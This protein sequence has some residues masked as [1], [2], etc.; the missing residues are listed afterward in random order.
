MLLS[1]MVASFPL[2]RVTGAKKK[3][4]LK[5]LSNLPLPPLQDNSIFLHQG[6]GGWF[7]PPGTLPEE[8]SEDLE[9]LAL[10][11]SA[12][13]LP[14]MATKLDTIIEAIADLRLSLEKKIDKIRAQPSQP[15]QAC[16]H[17]QNAAPEKAS[18]K[19]GKD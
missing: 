9:D 5:D 14:P 19:A 6:P 18:A 16:N 4:G 12:K 17:S 11:P 7:L 2:A 13:V 1:I 8:D 15:P 3:A 10:P